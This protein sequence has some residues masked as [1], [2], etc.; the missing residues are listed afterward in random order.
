MK[1]LFDSPFAFVLPQKGYNIVSQIPLRLTTFENR[2]RNTIWNIVLRKWFLALSIFYHGAYLLNLRSHVEQRSNT[3]KLTQ[4]TKLHF[5]AVLYN[6]HIYSL[7]FFFS[8]LVL[9]QLTF[10]RVSYSMLLSVKSKRQGM[11]K[12]QAMV[13]IG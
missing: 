4:N 1:S 11:S 7:G 10:F 3:E 2:L 8:G 5:V 9:F 13:G 12:W 6:T